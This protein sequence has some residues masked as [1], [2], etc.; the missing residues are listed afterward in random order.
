MAIFPQTKCLATF[1]DLE[2]LAEDIFQ[3]GTVPLPPLSSHMHFPIPILICWQSSLNKPFEVYIVNEN[4]VVSQL[5]IHL[6]P[7]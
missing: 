3:G 2:P 6:E 7:T 4:I 1:T 5:V